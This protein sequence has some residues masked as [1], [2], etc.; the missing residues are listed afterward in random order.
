MSVANP[1][2][3]GLYYIHAMLFRWRNSKY[4]RSNVDARTDAVA[5]VLDAGEYTHSVQVLM[6][7]RCRWR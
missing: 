5:G 6:M 7:K 1:Y 2:I 4:R 3:A